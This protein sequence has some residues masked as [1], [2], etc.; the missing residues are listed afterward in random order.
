MPAW[1]GYGRAYEGRRRLQRSDR[2]RRQQQADRCQRSASWRTDAW[3]CERSARSSTIVLQQSM[4]SS[5]W[6][7]CW[8]QHKE[9]VELPLRLDL[10]GIKAKRSS[11]T[12]LW[13]RRKLPLPT[14]ASSPLHVAAKARPRSKHANDLAQ[15]CPSVLLN[16]L[17][18]T[19]WRPLS[20]VGAVL[21]RP[22][23]VAADNVTSP[24]GV[25]VLARSLRRDG[26]SK[27][28]SASTIHCSCRQTR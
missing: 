13:Q 10:V 7:R 26:F 24:A 11:P 27:A 3:R 1:L 21:L 9:A 19:Q 15:I 18:P 23:M 16:G 17:A 22:L 28:I 20:A 25:T 5:G 12:V 6:S 8:V 4:I 2:G 14:S